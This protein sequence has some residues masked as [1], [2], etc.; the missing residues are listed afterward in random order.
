MTSVLTLE[1]VPRDKKA[2]VPGAAEPVGH[3]V[4]LADEPGGTSR[5]VA[6]VERDL[7]VGG[8]PA[9]RAA[10]KAGTRSFVLWADPERR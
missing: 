6:H 4:T 10:R 3:L 1:S 9:Y 5:P 8:I 7:P 2:A